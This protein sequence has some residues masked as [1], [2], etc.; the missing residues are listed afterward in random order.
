MKDIVYLA[1]YADNNLM[2]GDMA[3]IDNAI[4]PL[5]N[6]ALVLKTVEVPQDY[7]S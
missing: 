6:K 3:T 4:E 2:I 1:L 7:L 5:K